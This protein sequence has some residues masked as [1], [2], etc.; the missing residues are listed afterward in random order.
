MFCRNTAIFWWEL[1]EWG[2]ARWALG[3][4]ALVGGFAAEMALS[5]GFGAERAVQVIDRR[6]PHTIC[7]CGSQQAHDAVVV[8][9]EILEGFQR[10][11]GQQVVDFWWLR[12]L[13]ISTVQGELFVV[14]DQ[15]LLVLGE[16]AC[17]PQPRFALHID[18][19]LP[20][21]ML[22]GS[23]RAETILH[24][25]KNEQGG[26]FPVR[27]RRR[28]PV[29]HRLVLSCNSWLIASSNLRLGLSVIS[30]HAL[31]ISF[32]NLGSQGP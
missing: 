17:S 21:Q 12:E 14:Q 23:T 13:L 27:G 11:H 10:V 26:T 24:L 25:R 9:L 8:L 22:E 7:H 16:M 1:D 19:A 28:H 29:L 20:C 30:G 4:L 15:L 31:Q 3:V 18:K 5:A 32:R 6:C 2:Q